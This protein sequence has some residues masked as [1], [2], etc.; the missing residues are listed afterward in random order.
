MKAAAVFI[1][2]AMMLI[3]GC[4]TAEERLDAQLDKAM[5]EKIEYSEFYNDGFSIQ[6]PV[7]PASDSDVELS[8]TRGYCTVSA[9]VEKLTAKQWHTMMEEAVKDKGEI[10]E[11]DDNYIRYSMP[12]Q[13]I[14]MISENRIYD[15]NNN[16]IAVTITC[17]EQAFNKAGELREKVYSSAKCEGQDAAQPAQEQGYTTFTEDDFTITYPEWDKLNDNSEHTL[18]V[19]KGVCSIVVD[20][21]NALPE[22]IYNW[23]EQSNTNIEESSKE[24]D[25][26][27]ITYEL[28]YED[29]TVKSKAKIIYCNYQSYITQ[30]LCL[31]DITQEYED[32]RD[33]TLGSA[34]CTKIYEPPTKEKVEEQKKEI[35]ETNPEEIEEV[36]NEIVKTDAGDEFGIDGEAV[37]YFINSNAFFNKV[38]KDFPKANLVVEDKENNRELDIKATIDEEGKITLLED[39]QFEDADVTLTIPL[40]DALNIFGNAANINPLTLLGFAANVRTE[41]E[42]I[43]DE[44][45]QKALS[46]GYS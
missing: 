19:S 26:Y 23:Y 13:N 15:C 11:T 10:L 35:E 42:E 36:K 34:R 17:I 22:A 45:I 46:G 21:H 3:T 18:G 25:K 6:Y 37:V 14:T 2:I 16:A 29:K 4:S 8:V 28:P 41:P 24:G 9:N 33:E 44:V 7:W 27:Y 38:M 5:S 20:K 40:R 39:G 1:I 30:V 31:S 32:I 12:Y 43:K